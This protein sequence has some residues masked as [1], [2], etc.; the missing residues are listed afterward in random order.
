[1]AL[2]KPKV[3]KKTKVTKP[4]TGLLGE[5]VRAHYSAPLQQGVYSKLRQRQQTQGMVPISTV[6][7]PGGD[8]TIRLTTPQQ[9]RQ[10]P[11]QFLGSE[12]VRGPF[13][14][15]PRLNPDEYEFMGNQYGGMF[16]RPRT[17]FTGLAPQDVA[18][19]K[20]FDQL[21]DLQGQRIT[22][23]Y[24]AYA[25]QAG[26]D[27]DRA[28]QALGDLARL[29]GSGFTA[30]QGLGLSAV[31]MNLP[32]TTAATSAAGSMAQSA[33]TIADMNQLP[34]VAR[35]EGLNAGETFRATRFGQRQDM[36]SAL[37][38][39]Q[40][41][42]Q[43]A[44]AKQAADEAQFNRSL[45]SDTRGQNLSLL[46]QLGGQ[47]NA[48]QLAGIN[49]AADLQQAAMNNQADFDMAGLK[50]S[51]DAAAG[52]FRTPAKLRAA[53]FTGHWQVKPKKAPKG[54]ALEQA[55]D[56]TWYGKPPKGSASVSG[57]VDNN[58]RQLAIGSIMDD[59]GAKVP[60]RAQSAEEKKAG[61]DP[62]MRG[63]SAYEVAAANAK[64]FKV[65]F[66]WAYD[67]ARKAGFHAREGELLP[68]KWKNSPANARQPVAYKGVN[69]GG[70]LGGM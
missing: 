22:G 14:H 1:M 30:P 54:M 62:P 33:Q 40:A 31:E 24:D 49:N 29:A 42:S 70:L 65:P 60:T 48:L 38:Q 26:T 19:V 21:T 13:L 68:P 67:Q 2:S 52:Q 39:S 8:P 12:G 47:Q 59:V 16:A 53:G 28:T 43:A 4:L 25:T 58:T 61:I 35:S 23:A 6:D 11:S 3:V 18:N 34:T 69:F 5:F 55:S 56:G 27:R 57:G 64:E 36:L 44:A 32:G 37:R 9:R 17:E 66:A 50:A 63:L 45:A 20:A 15:N 7:E 51:Q 10:V 41:E 46:G